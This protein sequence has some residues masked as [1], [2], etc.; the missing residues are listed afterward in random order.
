MVVNNMTTI[1]KISE[2]DINTNSPEIKAVKEAIKKTNDKRMYQ[3]Y[4]VVFYHLKGYINKDISKILELCQHTVG[5]YVNK[6]KKNGLS[7]LSINHSPGAP[8][9]L[10]IEQETKLVE[11]ITTKTPAEVGFQN[12][13]V[14]DSFSA[15]SRLT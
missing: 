4:M 1:D 7:G 5:T 10:T 11:V 9:L 14:P 13:L 15:L 2:A 6:Y 8:R 12:N 3:R